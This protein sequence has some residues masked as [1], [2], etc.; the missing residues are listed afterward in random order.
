M[1]NLVTVVITAIAVLAASTS[2]A[3]DATV[4]L[5]RR[6]CQS[7][8]MADGK[9]P[10]PPMDFTDGE[11]KHGRS[12]AEVVKVIADGVAGT[13]MVAFKSQLTRSQIEAL[14]RYVR[15]FDKTAPA[16]KADAP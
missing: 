14:A 4:V 9:G 13:G 11:W 3:N 6:K 5:Y 10:L 16:K 15:A 1:L 8:H 7:C 2:H 12:Q